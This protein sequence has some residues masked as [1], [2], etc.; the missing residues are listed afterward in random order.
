MTVH[1]LILYLR[2][3]TL[4]S[5]KQNMFTEKMLLDQNVHP[6]GVNCLKASTEKRNSLI[7][8]LKKIK[9]N[10]GQELPF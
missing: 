7:E 10:Y 5:Q 9:I 8:T 6:F 1:V 4:V 2:Q 3:T